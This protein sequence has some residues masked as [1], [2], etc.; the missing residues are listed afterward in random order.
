MKQRGGAVQHY[1][2]F[3]GCTCLLGLTAAWGGAYVGVSVGGG[4]RDSRPGDVKAVKDLEAAW[5]NDAALKVAARFASYYA[6][7]CPGIVAECA[8]DRRKE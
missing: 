4:A 8:A 3:A 1:F 2:A 5:L 7:R 6:E